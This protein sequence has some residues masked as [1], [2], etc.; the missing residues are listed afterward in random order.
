MKKTAQ[1]VDAML[2]S[3]LQRSI[4]YYINTAD[5][6]PEYQ[7]FIDYINDIF[8][9]KVTLQRMIIKGKDAED[10]FEVV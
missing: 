3:T 9:K 8:F 6:E 10:I 5:D 2:R 4:N 1:V 7:P